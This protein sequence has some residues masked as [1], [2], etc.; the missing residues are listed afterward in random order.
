LI[1]KIGGLFVFS[2]V[3]SQE[4]PW[5]M[6]GKIRVMDQKG[7][8]KLRKEKGLIMRSKIK[9]IKEALRKLW[10][11][12]TTFSDALIF[13]DI[14][15][16][17]NRNIVD[18]SGMISIEH[19]ESLLEAELEGAKPVDAIAGIANG[20]ATLVNVDNLPHPLPFSELETLG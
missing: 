19:A 5:L 12:A 3:S 20:I 15:V 17:I 2:D 1:G 16:I 13:P 11:Y 14:F 9:D 8:V 18:L 7:F 4:Q 10:D 6:S